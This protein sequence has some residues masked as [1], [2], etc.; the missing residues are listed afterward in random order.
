MVAVAPVM[1][2]S[3]PQAAYA[4]KRADHPNQASAQEAKDTRDADGDGIHCES[5]P[6][7]CARPGSGD[8]GSK[9]K[10]KSGSRRRG[11]SRRARRYKGR[12]TSV[13]DGDTMKVNID[14]HVTTVRLIGI[15][16]PESRKPDT[17]VE[18]G[19]R[20]ATQRLRRLAFSPAGTPRRVT[21]VTD[22]S[23]SRRD[24]YGRLLG[25]VI[26]A[27]GRDF[28]RE[29]VKAGWAKTYRYQGKRY[30]KLGSYRRAQ[31][32]AK[33]KKRGV[34]RACGGNFHRPAN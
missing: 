22:P 11:S 29:L 25:Y 2:L 32:Y 15:D 10:S 18:C 4:A 9:S 34:W 7:P 3:S 27:R 20:K 12:V 31:T 28:N 17:P 19:S 6:C 1:A 24:R 14:D 5:L 13:V 8:S 23:Q 16:A 30:R 21:V 26:S 33:R